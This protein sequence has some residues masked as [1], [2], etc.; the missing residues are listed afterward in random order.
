M[1]GDRT[2]K[3]KI[4]RSEYIIFLPKEQRERG[5]TTFGRKSIKEKKRRKNREWDLAEEMETIIIQLWGSPYT[6]CARQRGA[7]STKFATSPQPLS[8]VFISS[9]LRPLG[10]SVHLRSLLHEPDS[11]EVD[12]S[13]VMAL[14]MM[15]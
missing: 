2:D 14:Y 4:Q 10:D 8:K 15:K 11:I 1:R 12:Y 3:Y 6:G 5:E 13:R 7:T 9:L